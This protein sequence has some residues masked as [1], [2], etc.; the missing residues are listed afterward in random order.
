M[1]SELY[2]T[3][4][5]HCTIATFNLQFLSR[6]ERT[7]ITFPCANSRKRKWKWEVIVSGRQKEGQKRKINLS[8]VFRLLQDAHWHQDFLLHEIIFFPFLREFY[9]PL[10]P[11]LS[12]SLFFL[13]FP[14]ISWKTAEEDLHMMKEIQFSKSAS[15]FLLRIL[16][17]L[18]SFFSLFP[19]PFRSFP[20]FFPARSKYQFAHGQHFGAE[21]LHQFRMTGVQWLIWFHL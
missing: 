10:F 16:G 18:A 13:R 1:L 15:P 5:A 4:C 11:A 21:L 8:T 12:K 20:A 7:N 9:R 14:E 3:F 17:I 2:A 6:G 19:R